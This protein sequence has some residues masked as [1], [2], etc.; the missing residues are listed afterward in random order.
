MKDAEMLF[1]ELLSNQLKK[2]Q[3]N[4][5]LQYDDLKR[6]TKY[7]DSSIFDRSHCCLWTGY[8]TNANSNNKGTYI[9]FYFMNKK[10]ALHRLLYI[11]YI[12][13]LNKDEYLKFSCD[14]KGRCCNIYHMNKFRYQKTNEDTKVKEKRIKEVK[15]KNIQIVH[16]EDKNN[17]DKLIINF[18]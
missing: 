15:S 2:I 10:V 18:D 16:K 9:N 11:N 7:I 5:R 17:M 8:I 3:G 6:I 13:P 1:I 14:N 4:Q 12:G